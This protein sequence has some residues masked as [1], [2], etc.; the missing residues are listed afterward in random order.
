MTH[1]VGAYTGHIAAGA[2]GHLIGSA[3]HTSADTLL[4][5]CDPPVGRARVARGA[6][7]AASDTHDFKRL[8]ARRSKP[9]L[10]PAPPFVSPGEKVREGVAGAL[11]NSICAGL[12]RCEGGAARAAS[13]TSV[14]LSARGLP[15]RVAAGCRLLGVAER[16]W[17]GGRALTRRASSFA[18]PTVARLDRCPRD[19]VRSLASAAPHR[20]HASPGEQRWSENVI[21]RG[22]HGKPGADG[23]RMHGAAQKNVPPSRKM[24]LWVAVLASLQQ[25]RVVAA[26]VLA[27]SRSRRSAINS[28]LGSARVLW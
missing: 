27:C 9:R 25:P 13:R 28:A 11:W 5:E 6:A 23:V 3:Y 17:P 8:L 21:G 20:Q 1:D 7:R 2:R 18:P 14:C 10:K 16:R 4:A 15:P 19:A 22:S 12:G 24:Y 26:P